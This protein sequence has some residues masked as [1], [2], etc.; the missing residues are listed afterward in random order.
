MLFPS[1]CPL[2][3]Q[4][5]QPPY[6]SSKSPEPHRSPFVEQV[7][8]PSGAYLLSHNAGKQVYTAKAIAAEGNT[9]FI[10]KLY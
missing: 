2:V 6:L 4:E 7:K 8:Q 9:E 10:P 1:P 3:V 5:T